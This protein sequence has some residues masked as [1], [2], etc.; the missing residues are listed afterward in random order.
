MSQ[1]SASTAIIRKHCPSWAKLEGVAFDG[2][3]V[4]R[5]IGRGG[6]AEVYLVQHTKSNQ[7]ALKLQLPEF[8][9]D[10]E[11]TKEFLR[12]IDILEDLDHKGIPK[13]I[14]H[15]QILVGTP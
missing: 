14:S 11:S 10:K 5:P 4:I 8:Q 2:W 12:E 13:M 6:T 15:A 1:E 9:D 3:K 7:S